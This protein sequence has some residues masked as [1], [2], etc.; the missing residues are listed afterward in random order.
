MT[1]E[2]HSPKQHSIWASVG[3]RLGQG[4]PN[5]G[6]LLGVEHEMIVFTLLDLIAILIAV[7]TVC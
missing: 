7:Y 4:G 1:G 6:M 5:M 3:P 2:K